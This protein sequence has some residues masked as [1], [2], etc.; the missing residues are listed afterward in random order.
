MSQNSAPPDVRLRVPVNRSNVKRTG[1]F[2]LV[3]IYPLLAH[4]LGLTANPDIDG[5]LSVLREIL[6]R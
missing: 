5:D 2:K 3:H 4:M 1:A 6:D